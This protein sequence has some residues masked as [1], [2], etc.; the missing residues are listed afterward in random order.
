MIKKLIL[1][2]KM[3]KKFGRVHK[4]HVSD[5]C[6]MLRAMCSQVPGF[7]KYM[8]EA[9]T[10]GIR[11]A[12]FNGKK[13]ITVE[14][15]EMSGSGEVYR[16]V[17]ILEG[18]KQGGVLQIVIGAVALV[19]AFFTAGASLAA[20]GAAMS[21]TAISATTLLTAMGASMILGGVVQLLTP[22]A[23]YGAGKS[24]STDNTPNYAFGSPVNTVAM[25]HPVPVLYGDR[26]VGG[27]VIS[28]GMF[29]E[30]QR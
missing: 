4:F 15:F 2:G 8:L 5:L 13:N 24:S 12:F 1:E 28:A 29:S 14:E 30:D 26:E 10:N 27:A 22:Q 20:W 21:A 11:F 25:G 18:S 6:E 3:A 16:I 23:N 17:P 9:H 19:A 7:R